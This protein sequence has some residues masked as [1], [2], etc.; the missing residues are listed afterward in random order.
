MLGSGLADD[1]VSLGSASRVFPLTMTRRPRPNGTDTDTS[2]D[3]PEHWP[4][5]LPGTAQ[6]TTLL[7]SP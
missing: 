6:A 2:G 4:R 3:I 1:A 7:G 5:R